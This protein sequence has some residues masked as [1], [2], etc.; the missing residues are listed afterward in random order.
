MKSERTLEYF[1][2]ISP[3]YYYVKDIKRRVETMSNE[4]FEQLEVEMKKAFHKYNRGL[5]RLT[6]R[7]RSRSKLYLH[8]PGILLSDFK[9]FLNWI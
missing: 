2:T 7:A 6:K 3:K 9:K 5:P 4:E 8:E 1:Y